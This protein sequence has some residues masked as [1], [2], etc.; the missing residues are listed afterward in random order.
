MGSLPNGY[1]SHHFV[2]FLKYPV[3]D[4][5]HKIQFQFSLADQRILYN[6]YFIP[7]KGANLPYTGEK[8]IE[9]DCSLLL[10]SDG[11]PNTVSHK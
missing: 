5:N 4:F 1:S 7:T 8:Q 10:L 6:Q 9:G 11:L 2:S 3:F